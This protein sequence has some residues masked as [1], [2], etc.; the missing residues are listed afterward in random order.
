MCSTPSRLSRAILALTS[1]FLLLRSG[2]ACAEAISLNSGSYVEFN[3]IEQA[4][5]DIYGTLSPSNVL[6]ASAYGQPDEL[7]LKPTGLVNTQINNDWNLVFETGNITFNIKAKPGSTLE[8]VA[9]EAAGNYVLQMSQFESTTKA[10]AT[11]EMEIK[12]QI[13]G[14]NGVTE[15]GRPWLTFDKNGVGGGSDG[16]LVTSPQSI[17]QELA[18]QG[19]V[20][21]AWNASFLRNIRGI[22]GLAELSGLNLAPTDYVT[23]ISLS[24]TTSLGAESIF[25]AATS[26]LNTVDIGVTAQPVPE[27]PTIILAGL[28]AAAAVGHGYRRR[29]LRQ[30]DGEGSDGEW[31]GEEGAIALTA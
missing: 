1:A 7:S 31:N 28:G 13:V 20:T 21:Q 24:L 10:Y 11:S 25:A 12:L 8:T 16:L 6:S 27:P 3:R 29:K 23:E 19:L 15:T 4:P 5:P 18:V 9:M 17:L 30:R 14:I 2:S 22:G 26:R